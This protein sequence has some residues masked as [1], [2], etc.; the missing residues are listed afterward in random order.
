MIQTSAQ[1]KE[2]VMQMSQTQRQWQL[3]IRREEELL[4]REEKWANVERISRAQ[5]YK[6]KLILD[7]IE[8]DNS[9]TESLQAEKKKLFSSRAQ[10]RR[11][12]DR[13][14]QKI[15]ETFEKMRKRG[16]LDRSVLLQFG[17]VVPEEV[18]EE[19]EEHMRT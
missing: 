1:K 5:E 19:N 3:M 13:Q 6:K 12:A 17:V 10:I 18:K 8:Y 11:D 9:K 2:E 7:K 14:K 4:R 16:R 15:V